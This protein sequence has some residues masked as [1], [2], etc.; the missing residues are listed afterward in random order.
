MEKKAT[1]PSGFDTESGLSP[2]LDPKYASRQALIESYFVKNRATWIWNVDYTTI[3]ESLSMTKYP[4]LQLAKGQK[5]ETMIIEWNAHMFSRDTKRY[6]FHARAAYIPDP[7]HCSDDPLADYTAHLDHEGINRAVLV[8]PE[9]YGD[10]HRLILDCL[11]RAPERFRGTCLFYPDDPDAPEK[12][13]NLVQQEP[14]IVAVRFHAHR[15]KEMYLPSFADAGVHALWKTAGE[16][17]LIIELHIGPNYAAQAAKVIASHPEFPVLV[18]HLAEAKMGNAVEYADVLDLARFDNVYMKL[19]GLNH[20]STQA[21]LYL[22]AK[23]F[24][25]WVANAFGPAHLV[26]GSGT[27]GIV[28]AHLDFMSQADRALVKGKNLAK[29]LNW[30]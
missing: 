23:P 25:R 21:P 5:G 14:R 30:S 10:D 4:K 20:F 16:L 6:P 3:I 22:D 17:G 12:L 15:G 9:P 29:L 18:D 24:T 13:K 1:V 8:H 19:S 11:R 27:P 2:A 26:W 28:D 7:A